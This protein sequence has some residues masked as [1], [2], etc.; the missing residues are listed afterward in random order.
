MKVVLVMHK[1]KVNR[2]QDL[3]G[4]GDPYIKVKIGDVEKE[5]HVENNTLEPVWEEGI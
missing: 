4:N 2:K 3:I 5:T 1:G